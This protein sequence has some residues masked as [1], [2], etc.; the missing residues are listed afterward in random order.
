M[1]ANL[2]LDK[3]IKYGWHYDNSGGSHFIFKKNNWTCFIW[4]GENPYVNFVRN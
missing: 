2:A 3:L 1:D 4:I